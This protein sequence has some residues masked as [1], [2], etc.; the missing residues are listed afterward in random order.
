MY[1]KQKKRS[2]WTSLLSH[3]ICHSELVILQSGICPVYTDCGR[4]IRLTAACSNRWA[5]QPTTLAAVKVGVNNSVG[6]AMARIIE[7]A[8]NSTFAYSWR[9]GLYSSS[10]RT[11]ACS[12]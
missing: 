4:K 8:K 7:A 10:R 1:T 5:D 12:T 6:R 9:P 2:L 11:A 3:L